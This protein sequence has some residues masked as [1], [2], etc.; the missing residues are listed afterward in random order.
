[1]L[2]FPALELLEGRLKPW[3]KKSCRKGGETASS[4]L[5]SHG[6]KLHVQQ[7]KWVVLAGATK[8]RGAVL[9]CLPRAPSLESKYV[10]EE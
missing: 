6:C 10:T 8:R 3:A 5:G 4:H 7:G 1:M 2:I 9:L